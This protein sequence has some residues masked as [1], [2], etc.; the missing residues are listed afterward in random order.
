MDSRKINEIYRI[1]NHSIGKYISNKSLSF[2]EV[3]TIYILEV[4]PG[5]IDL[6]E[7]LKQ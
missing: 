3:H 6:I 1:I 5:K 2:K 7:L 4:D